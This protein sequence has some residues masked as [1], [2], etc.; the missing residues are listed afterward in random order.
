MLLLLANRAAALPK[1][2]KQ[3]FSGASPKAESVLLY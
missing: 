3:S 2:A 1:D